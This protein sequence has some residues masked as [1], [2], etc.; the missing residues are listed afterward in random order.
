M[1]K[2]EHNVIAHDLG[3]GFLDVKG[4]KK[5]IL[6]SFSLSNWMIGSARLGEGG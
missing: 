1:L 4:K 3:F 2:V 5:R 6:Q